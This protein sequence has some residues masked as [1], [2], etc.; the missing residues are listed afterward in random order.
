MAQ[1]PG[2][3]PEQ[4]TRSE[5]PT[6]SPTDGRAARPRPSAGA[7]A[8]LPGGLEA[9]A[10]RL[11]ALVGALVAASKFA[12]AG[13]AWLGLLVYALSAAVFWYSV[14]PWDPPTVAFPAAPRVRLRRLDFAL[15]SLV[16]GIAFLSAT[17]G[18]PQQL[19]AGLWV[20]AMLLALA[21]GSRQVESGRSAVTA[22][23]FPRRELALVLAIGLLALAL[24]SWRL[25]LYPN[26]F[27][28]DEGIF[29]R[30]AWAI[31]QGKG[32][33][34]F[35]VGEW[36]HP[37]GYFHL[38]AVWL[39]ILGYGEVP[40]RAS[41]A[42]NGAVLVVLVYFLGRALFGKRVAL[43]AAVLVCCNVG[44]LVFSRQALGLSVLPVLWTGAFLALWAGLQRGS[45]KLLVL[46]GILG[47][48]GMYTTFAALS[49]LATVAI[50]AAAVALLT[51][52]IRAYV[53]PAL[54]FGLGF[55][56][57][58]APLAPAYPLVWAHSSSRLLSSD[59]RQMLAIAGTTDL[60]PVYWANLIR[61]L[62]GLFVANRE[63]FFL[64]GLPLL[65]P[66][67]GALFVLGGLYALVRLRDL[68]FLLLLCWLVVMFICNA[69]INSISPQAHRLWFGTAPMLLLAAVAIDR[70]LLLGQPELGDRARR[71]ARRY[72]GVA[73][74]TVLVG[75]ICVGGLRAFFT[76]GE[77]LIMWE[78]ASSQARYIAQLGPKVS[79]GLL[80]APNIYF[81]HPSRQYLAP[82][83]IGMNITRWPDDLDALRALGRPAVFIVYPHRNADL[84]RLRAAFPE[85]QERAIVL[86]VPE[87]HTVF[88]AFA[89]EGLPPPLQPLPPDPL[90]QALF[91]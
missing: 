39:A 85:G 90:G 20:G 57:A 91:R 40:L 77:K 41:D 38:Y 17:R 83:A 78:T 54:L 29:G 51:R 52:Q 73:L 65:G 36:N 30:E 24:R 2:L 59:P 72:G 62:Q 69:E 55:A 11:L 15:A 76:H 44:F 10:M 79:I 8:L 63:G 74:A 80:G 28:G 43:L 42:C 3:L 81:D 18:A 53:R 35:G 56:A 12:L 37:G 14:A 7:G 87:P 27:H 34:L 50:F 61:N 68:R 60:I 1:M 89:T 9:H 66:G 16:G 22:A 75:V 19:L 45:G 32:A 46:A 5:Q 84:E 67:E 6:A 33:P 47:G 71:L 58:F 49:W 26:G 21:A 4:Q 48:L 88:T 70:T 31:L 64:P 86:P 82:Q 25:D 13:N 23:R